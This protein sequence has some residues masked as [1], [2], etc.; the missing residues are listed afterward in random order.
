MT[1]N[2][3][4]ILDNY[5]KDNLSVPLTVGNKRVVNKLLR[6]LDDSHLYPISGRYNATNRAINHYNYECNKY[7]MEIC[8]CVYSY[9]ATLEQMISDYVNHE[10]W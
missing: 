8:D 2:Y 9:V 6:K 10:R 5:V 1:I 3:Q 4:A 7:G